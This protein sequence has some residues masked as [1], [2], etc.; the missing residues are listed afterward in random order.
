MYRK[1]NLPIFSGFLGIFAG[2]RFVDILSICYFFR[3]WARPQFFPS[4]TTYYILHEKKFNNFFKLWHNDR[5]DI[6]FLLLIEN[7]VSWGGA[8]L[9]QY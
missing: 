5:H 8:I 6:L 2:S 1:V 9:S 7:T 4:L 3:F